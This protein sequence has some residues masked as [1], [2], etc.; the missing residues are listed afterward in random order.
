MRTHRLLILAAF[1]AVAGAAPAATT[2]SPLDGTWKWTWTRAQIVPHDGD[3][4]EAGTHVA[5]FADGIVTSRNLRT[6]R[7]ER[8]RFS[9]AGNV[10]DF[11]FG[12][13]MSPRGLVPGTAY[14]VRWSIYRDRLTFATV[15]GRPTL[16]LLPVTPWI[17]VR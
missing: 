9:V 6:G 11:V 7:V 8:A 1:A 17:R 4:S 10:V 16:G 13:S 3:P 12:T 2:T 5:T 15:R 14:R